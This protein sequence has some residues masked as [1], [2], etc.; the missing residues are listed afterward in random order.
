MVLGN[1][2]YFALSV[3]GLGAHTI[4]TFFIPPYPSVFKHSDQKHVR[5]EMLI[6]KSQDLS[7]RV[8]PRNIKVSVKGGA[9]VRNGVK[10]TFMLID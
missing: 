4:N 6:R 9:E 5:G 8:K 1:T 7:F 2:K 10:Y 3:T